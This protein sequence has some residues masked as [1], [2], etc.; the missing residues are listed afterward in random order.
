MLDDVDYNV[1]MFHD[2]DYD[3]CWAKCGAII[4]LTGECSREITTTMEWSSS[5]RSRICRATPRIHVV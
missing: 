3:A 4:Y 5:R 2:E 1:V